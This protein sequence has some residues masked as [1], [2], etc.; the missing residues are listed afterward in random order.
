MLQICFEGV[1]PVSSFR[2]TPAEKCRLDGP[3]LTGAD[4]AII[5]ECRRGFWCASQRYYTRV[6]FSGPVIIEL[7]N[8]SHTGGHTC[9]AFASAALRGIMLI[10]DGHYLAALLE[11]GLWRCERTQTW[12]N[13]VRIAEAMTT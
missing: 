6:I 10:G 1:T 11:S 8:S 2:C 3:M 9:G 12:W 5:A 7:Y 4:G 13:A